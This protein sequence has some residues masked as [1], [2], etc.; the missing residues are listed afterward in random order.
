KPVS[1]AAASGEASVT[2]VCACWPRPTRGRD[3]A[4]GDPAYLPPLFG[5]P[6]TQARTKDVQRVVVLAVRI[7]ADV[8]A[9]RAR[10]KGHGH[11]GRQGPQERVHSEEEL[12]RVL[13]RESALR[14]VLRHEGLHERERDAVRAHERLV[15]GE[16]RGGGRGRPG[17]WEGRQHRPS[18]AR[19]HA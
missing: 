13:A 12:Q 2:T 14:L 1:S 3:G 19:V 10:G 7:A 8:E 6:R 17:R 16:L 18:V 9:L 11:E 15:R 4:T 5:R